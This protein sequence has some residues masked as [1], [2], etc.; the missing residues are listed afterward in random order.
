M[1][2]KERPTTVRSSNI[3]TGRISGLKILLQG[4]FLLG[5]LLSQELTADSG[6]P[7]YRHGFSLV[8]EQRY[9]PD[10][11]HFEYL[12]PNAPKGGALVLST[13][14]D[15]NNFSSE[16]SNTVKVA[17]G[18]AQTYDFLLTRADDELSGYYGSL[19]EGVAVADDLLSIAF[20]LRPEARW[21]DGAPITAHDVKFTYDYGKGTMDGQLFADWLDSVEILGRHEVRIKLTTRLTTANLALFGYGQI[22]PARYWKGK[23]PSETT[24]EVPLGSG[25]YRVAEF[26][27][28]R[29]IRYERVCDYWGKDLPVNRG[30]FNFDEIRY[31]VYRDDTV[32]REALHKGLFDAYVEGDI[33]HWVSSY[34]VPS[35]DKGWLVL[36]EAANGIFIGPAAVVAFNVRHAPFDDPVVRE[37]LALALDYKWLNRVLNHGLYEQPRSYFANSVFASSGLPDSAE[38]ALLEPFRDTVPARVFTDAF[39]N[40]QSRGVGR[41]RDALLRARKLLVQAGWRIHD[42]VLVNE[43]GKPFEI[44]FL[45]SEISQR[46]ILLPYI[47]ALKV[48]GINAQI[49]LVESAQLI[50]RRRSY[51]FDAM[52]QGF[53]LMVPPDLMASYFL[54]SS[55]ANSPVT[56]NVAGIADPV[57]DFLI[58]EGGVATTLEQMVA[59]ARALDRVLLWNFYHVPLN[60]FSKQRIVH[61]NKFGRADLG[62][63]PMNQ[64]VFPVGWWYDEHKAAQI[65]GNE[66]TQAFACP[67]E[68]E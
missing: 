36:A 11:T 53:Y 26:K 38:L 37:A 67:A 27:Q 68:Q 30:R 48:L 35:R 33:R 25:P 2:R 13:S 34:N 41:N 58:N 15:I 31:D 7:E 59:S 40:P 20:R 42:G 5:A 10:F 1:T 6:K 57:I 24:M 16:W 65:P 45:S 9:P 49:R 19:A 14:L 28:G 46:R 56:G 44:E 63:E 29:Y 54:H 50:N 43:D 52:I 21:H 62:Y 4:A 32:A 22:L 64:S 66:T 23:N 12:N 17:P 55:A 60:A 47:D 8:N 3:D 61:W 51:D 18:M 39:D